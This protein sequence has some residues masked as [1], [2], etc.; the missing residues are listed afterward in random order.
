[1]YQILSHRKLGAATV[2]Q[3][4]F[5]PHAPKQRLNQQVVRWVHLKLCRECVMINLPL[6]IQPA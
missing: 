1:M 3:G 5:G 6:Q 4:C 2:D